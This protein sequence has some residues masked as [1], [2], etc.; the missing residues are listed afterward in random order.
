VYRLRLKLSQLGRQ[1]TLLLLLL[2]AGTSPCRPTC[3]SRGSTEPLVLGAAM[4][5]CMLG[6]ETLFPI[7]ILG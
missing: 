5:V 2:K 3:G 7:L 4:R 1:T 6:S